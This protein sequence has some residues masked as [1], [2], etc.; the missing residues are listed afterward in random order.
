MNSLPRPVISPPNVANLKRV[1]K[2][3][4]KK[5]SNPTPASKS[6]AI[7]NKPTA[8][9]TQMLPKPIYNKSFVEQ[10]MI[11]IVI[12][13]LGVSYLIFRNKRLN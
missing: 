8:T 12:V 13:G 5:T 7:S 1:P 11:P 2:P 10:N 6:P 3:Q 4:L 9:K